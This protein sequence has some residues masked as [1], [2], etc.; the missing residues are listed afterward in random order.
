MCIVHLLRSEQPAANMWIEKQNFTASRHL[1]EAASSVDF[2][3]A[4]REKPAYWVENSA[5][6]DVW[7]Y[8]RPADLDEFTKVML[9]P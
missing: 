7:M 8:A 2:Y 9:T 1:W 5:F 3:R 4:W 6:R